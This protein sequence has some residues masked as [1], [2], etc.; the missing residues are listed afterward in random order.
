MKTLTPLRSRLCFPKH[1]TPNPNPPFLI[2][3]KS[4]SSHLKHPSSSSSSSSVP[5]RTTTLPRQIGVTKKSLKHKPQIQSQKTCKEEFSSHVSP[6]GEGGNSRFVMIGAVTVGLVVLVMGGG[7]LD[8]QKAWALGPEGPLMEEFWD[9]MRRY[10]L[11]AL[12]VS[13]GVAYT[14]LQ[15]ILELLKNPISAILI[16]TI[17]VGCFYIVSQ[18]LNAMV[19]VSD[20]SYEYGY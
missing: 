17:F 3:I 15:P 19:G 6:K 7:V 20:F 12:T 1:T 18:V 14:L 9:N 16:I 11:Y 13:T 10:A 4:I 8:D 5:P 2:H